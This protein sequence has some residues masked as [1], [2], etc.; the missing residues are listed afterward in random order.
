VVRKREVF[1]SSGTGEMTS[2][3]FGPSE[4][5]NLIFSKEPNRVDQF[6]KG[7]VL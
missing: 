6:P 4:R 1:P 5:A 2:T 7:Y 3:L